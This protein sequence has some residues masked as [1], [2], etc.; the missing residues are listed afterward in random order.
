ML[1]LVSNAMLM[2]IVTLNVLENAFCMCLD[3][4]AQKHL[5]MRSNL[6]CVQFLIQDFYPNY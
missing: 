5:K 1:I 3:I 6:R 2:D 4:I